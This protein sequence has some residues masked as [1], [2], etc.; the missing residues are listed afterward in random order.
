[1]EQNPSWEADQFWVRQEILHILWK[2]NVQYHTYKSPSPVPILSQINPVHTSHLTFWRSILISSQL[3]LGHPSA[4]FPSGFPTKTLY[5][6]LLPP[7][8]CH[9]PCPSHSFRVSTIGNN[10]LIKFM[11]VSFIVIRNAHKLFLL[12]TPS[13]KFVS[14]CSCISVTFQPVMVINTS[15]VVGILYCLIYLAVFV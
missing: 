15:S 13:F 1:M 10:I 12:L 3:R 6:P 2:P 11:V 9:M 14:T 7:H 8:M 5:T 4:L